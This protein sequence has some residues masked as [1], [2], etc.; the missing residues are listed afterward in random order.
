MAMQSADFVEL[1]VESLSKAVYSQRVPTVD[2]PLA[3]Y[4]LY[5][6]QPSCKAC[7]AT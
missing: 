5:Q 3:I 1:C 4:K 2:C 6:G 7:F